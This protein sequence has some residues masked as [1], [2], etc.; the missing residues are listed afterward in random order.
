MELTQSLHRAAAVHPEKPITVHDGRRRTF[1]EHVERV[2]RLAGALRERGVE[3][4]DRVA[5]LALNSDRYLEY[6]HACWWA[7]AVVVPVNVRWSADEI[8]FSLRDSD[9]RVLL[10]DD[11]FTPTLEQLAALEHPAALVIHAGDGPTP[12]G[13][14]PY[15][16]LA[17]NG[18]AVEDA[19][20][21]D[22][23]L[24]GVFYTGGTTGF[25]KGVMLSH[26]NLLASAWG[27]QAGGEFLPPGA[28]LLHAAPMFHLADMAAGLAQAALGGT[29]AMVPS[30]TPR[31][32]LRAI[33]EHEIT[34]VLLVP[35]MIQMLLDDPAL[36]EHDI[37]TLRR[38]LYGGS[39]MTLGV[40]ERAA[41]RLPGVEF[42]QAYGMTELSPVATLLSAE[43]HRRG[44]K[45]RSGGRPVAHVEIRI[46]DP[47]GD[48]LPRGETGEIC[49][50]GAN[51]MQG[52]WRRPEETARALRDGWL[53]TGDGG[54]MDEDGYVFVV[55]RIK[56]MI[57]TGGEN[58][59][60]AEVEMALSTHPAV[61]TCAVIGVP[62]ERWGE[63]VH[64]VV[65]PAD[66][67]SPTLEDLRAHVRGQIA[68]YKAPRSVDVTETLP[69]S[70]AG[71][72]LKRT[73]REQFA[74]TRTR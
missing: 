21:A 33:V 38:V 57:V 27:T 68:D 31:A 19:R 71:K 67:R 41:A 1:A 13:A 54:F 17:T 61:A 55:D 15:E 6:F 44:R 53:H 49:V 40:L 60:S 50:R 62:D 35:T 56:D 66:G 12:P 47:A 46:C 22:A 36:A 5:M 3:A 10:V 51:V 16:Q 18:P 74:V 7:G 29:H 23:D 25:P 24:A 43:D 63:R 11:A 9:T 52:Y 37:S 64:A 8:A 65:V 20:R 73:L 39:P 26:R 45:L 69:L 32:T 48:E 30:F 4:G 42:V 2:R 59:Y 28:R 70:G 14:E 58:V 34:H 72:V